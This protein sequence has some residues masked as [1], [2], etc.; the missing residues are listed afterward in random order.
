LAS[1]GARTLVELHTE[2]LSGGKGGYYFS[3]QPY[4]IEQG[5]AP[6]PLASLCYDYVDNDFYSSV[7]AA[8]GRVAFRAGTLHGCGPGVVRDYASQ[9][10]MDSML[11]DKAFALRLAGNMAAWLDGPQPGGTVGDPNRVIVKDLVTGQ[12]VFSLA[13]NA[14]PDRVQSLSLQADGK[15]ALTYVDRKA[16]AMRVA[17]GYPG[18]GNTLQKLTSLNA[19]FVKA[20][21]GS[22]RLVVARSIDRGFGMRSLSETDLRGGHQRL[23]ARRVIDSSLGD[24]FAFDG[25]RV[26]WVSLG[27]GEAQIHLGN[28]DAVT[29]SAPAAVCPLRLTH[30]YL[31]VRGSRFAAQVDCAG[32]QRGCSLNDIRVTT[33][34]RGSQ[35]P[36]SWLRRTMRPTLLFITYSS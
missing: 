31:K 30:N 34:P 2:T 17:V 24:R 3:S 28:I 29:A 25:Q 11:G 12:Q 14:L 9:P 8:G 15:V 18:P 20:K 1:S 33:R 7:A 21:I 23:L 27:C 5:Q 16:V 26:A 10:A 19:D 35:S 4:L 6:Q 36:W 13:P 32:I 22:D